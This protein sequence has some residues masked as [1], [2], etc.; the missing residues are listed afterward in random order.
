MS[1]KKL[2]H[3]SSASNSNRNS[4]KS[5]LHQIWNR[6]PQHQICNIDSHNKK[7]K[8]PQQS[9]TSNLK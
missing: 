3:K 8:K 5:H 4:E 2:D 9:S 1:K 7:N 6:N